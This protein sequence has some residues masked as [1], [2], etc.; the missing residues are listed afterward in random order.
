MAKVLLVEDEADL[1]LLIKAQLGLAGLECD[2][3]AGLD[4]A[5][6]KLAG[7]K[8]DAV[9]LDLFLGTESG[10]TLIGELSGRLG[11]RP[12]VIVISA[13]D[14]GETRERAI[15]AGCEWL[16][17]PFTPAELTATLDRVLP[18]HT[19]PEQRPSEAT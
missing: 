3:A 8:F 12:P 10:W 7:A 19:G 5:R 6:G 17:K 1:L 14:A 18:G 9:L 13:Y 16:P 15:S 4:E 11:P 2:T